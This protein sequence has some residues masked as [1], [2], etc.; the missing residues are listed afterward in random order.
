[1]ADGQDDIAGML[2]VRRS[3]VHGLGAFATRR[4]EKGARVIEYLG[5]RVSHEEADRRYEYK[6]AADSHTFLFI[7]DAGTVIDAGVNGNDARFLNH[8]CQPNC[9][10]VIEGG[11]VFIEALVEIEPGTELTY[12]YQI[13][14]EADDPDD[15]DEVFACHC[16]F[17]ACRGSMLWPPRHEAG[18][19]RSRG[20]R[21][22]TAS[23]T[24]P[25]TRKEAR[26]GKDTRSRTD[27]GSRMDTRRLKDTRTPK[28]VR[29]GKDAR[30]HKDARRNGPPHRKSAAAK[31]PSSRRA[32][33]R[34]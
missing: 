7:V 23:G 8:S 20:R 14:R 31:R 24:Q 22:H 27:A 32:S 33:R 3:P 10:S 13:Q 29:S 25:R 11:R 16:G 34:R 9:E 6:D 4:I 28:D 26:S 21:K 19:T 15:V 1:M 17:P 30:S 5:E 18:A 2:E 12:D